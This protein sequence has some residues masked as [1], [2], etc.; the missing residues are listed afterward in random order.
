MGGVG[1]GL[2]MG[3]RLGGVSEAV[4]VHM[5]LHRRRLRLVDGRRL[6]LCVCLCLCFC[7]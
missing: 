4:G 2:V 7:L 1:R 3:D 5:R 6:V